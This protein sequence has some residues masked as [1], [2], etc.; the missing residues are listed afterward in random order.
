MRAYIQLQCEAKKRAGMKMKLFYAGKTSI[1]E[2]CCDYVRK[3][4]I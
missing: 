1:A 2:N 3:L 4:V